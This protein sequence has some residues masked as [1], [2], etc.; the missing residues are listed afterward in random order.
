MIFVLPEITDD[1]AA[2]CHSVS[3]NEVSGGG[4]GHSEPPEMPA[5]SCTAR[6]LDR[7]SHR[8]IPPY[9]NHL[10][11]IQ[12]NPLAQIY[13]MLFFFGLTVGVFQDYYTKRASMLMM[14]ASLLIPVLSLIR[15]GS[16][17]KMIV[18]MGTTCFILLA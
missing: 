16:Q 9:P 7:R 15:F 14:W 2:F 8:P 6:L 17:E 11:P 4:L 5:Q 10:T 18:S 13:I 12:L 3:W 1:T